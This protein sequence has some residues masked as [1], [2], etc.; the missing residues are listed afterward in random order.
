M[1]EYTPMHTSGED[2]MQC[3]QSVCQSGKMIKSYKKN[4]AQPSHPRIEISRASRVNYTAFIDLPLH[5]IFQILLIT[6]IKHN[7]YEPLTISTIVYLDIS[8]C[9]AN[10][11]FVLVLIRIS[12][13][14]RKQGFSQF[15]VLTRSPRQSSYR[16]KYLQF[17]HSTLIM[18][19]RYIVLSSQLIITLKAQYNLALTS[20]R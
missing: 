6:V 5:N 3:C 14:L 11:V 15:P 13:E 12:T 16:Y 4:P 17:L 20:A 9:A 7:V 18:Y 1:V 19:I 10:F 8:G 2:C